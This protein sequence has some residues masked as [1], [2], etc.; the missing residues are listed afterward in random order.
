M[1]ASDLKS[2]WG[3]EWTRWPGAAR[4]V[5]QTARDV[6]RRD[7]NE[8]V[9]LEA[10]AS[11]GR[12][13][14]RATVV[15]DDGRAESFRRLTARISG[16][17]DFEREIPLEPAGVGTYASTMPL[18]RIGAYLV[19]ARDDASGDLLGTTGAV[20]GAGEEVRP[21]GT[22]RALLARVAE[23][24]GGRKLATL[25]GVF[26]DRSIERF[27]YDDASGWLTALGALLLVASVAARRLALPDALV[28]WWERRTR[29]REKRT[30]PRAP[31]TSGAS[32]SEP[33]T[34]AALR[35]ARSANPSTSSGHGRGT[36]APSASSLGDAATRAPT[37]TDAATTPAPSGGTEPSPQ[38]DAPRR[39]MR[40]MGSHPIATPR[41]AP[42]PKAPPPTA[43]AASGSPANSPRTNEHAPRPKSAAELLAEKRRQR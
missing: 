12:L 16:P 24:T 27:A 1:F 39:G 3:A 34:L 29:T 30:L 6:A 42:A 10:D 33:A 38:A 43:P 14:V 32:S 17:G 22:D 8:R 19:V 21:T 26:E 25:A 31:G 40:V 4:L 41:A 15:G 11:G 35:R 23:T 28:A 36:T 13:V 5:A 37:Q 2:R 18:D 7:E 20:L 9:R